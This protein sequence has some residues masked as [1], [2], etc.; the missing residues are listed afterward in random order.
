MTWNENFTLTQKHVEE[1]LLKVLQHRLP[2][3]ADHFVGWHSQPCLQPLIA[4]DAVGR[5]AVNEMML[6]G[7]LGQIEKREYET[8]N[9]G[10][11]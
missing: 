3:H 9:T 10:H 4:A 5:L 1:H 7:K 2:S 11:I 8:A 6:K